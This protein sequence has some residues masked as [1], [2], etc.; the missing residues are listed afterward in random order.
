MSRLIKKLTKIRQAEPQPMGFAMSRSVTESTGMQLLAYITSDNVDKLSDSLGSA[1]AVLVEVTKSDAVS[2]LERICQA[3]DGAPCGG[4]IKSSNSG[5]LKKALNIACDFVVFPAVT[6]LIALPK[7]KMGRI[8]EVDPAWTEAL[9]RTV[10]D[11][12]VEAILIAGKDAEIVITLNRLMLL[13]RLLYA[14]NKP[15]LAAVPANITETELQTLWDM[16]ISGLIV[17][18]NDA[19]SARV[20][21]ELHQIIEKLA[22]PAFRKKGRASAILPRLSAE[23]PESKEGEEEEGDE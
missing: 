9:L 2:S 19:E 3:K 20:I 12:P 5:T 13:Q 6:Q 8:L 16:G 22:P 15:I 1:D 14:V 18:V 4:W 21:S 23:A 17:E 11:L 10:N 7:E